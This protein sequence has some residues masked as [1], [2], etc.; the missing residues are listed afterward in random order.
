MFFVSFNS[1]W[2]V[3]VREECNVRAAET[4]MLKAIWAEEGGTDRKWEKVA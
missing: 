1:S 4:A 2:S 3:P